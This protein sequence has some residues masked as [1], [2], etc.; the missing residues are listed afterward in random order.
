MS[1]LSRLTQQSASASEELAATSEELSGQ[2]MQLQQTMG[3][4]KVGSAEPE[5][6]APAKVVRLSKRGAPARSGHKRLSAPQP[7]VEHD[8][9]DFEITDRANG[10]DRGANANGLER[11]GKIKGLDRINNAA[12]QHFERF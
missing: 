4:F 3:F 10:E 5:Q 6:E 11:L 7:T 1:Q 8:T 2:A 12:E 9:A